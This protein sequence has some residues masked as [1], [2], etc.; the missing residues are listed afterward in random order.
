M[1]FR[2]RAKKGDAEAALAA[3]PVSVDLRYTTPPLQQNAIEPH[4]TIAVWDGDRLTLH[5]C[6]QYI[7]AARNYIAQRFGRATARTSG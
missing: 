4:A 2:G 7:E 1:Y 6:T 5:D 3:A